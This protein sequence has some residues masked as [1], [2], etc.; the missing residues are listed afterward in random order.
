MPN[1]YRQ[2]F[3][4]YALVPLEDG[5]FLPVNRLY[6]PLGIA[7]SDFV[8]YEKHPTRV[9]IN[10]LTARKARSIGLEVK[11]EAGSYFYFYSDRNNP[12]RSSS[13]WNRYQAI[14]SKLMKMTVA[15]AK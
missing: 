14:L 2:I 5:S 7:S 15:P 1:T 6:K 11:E 9:K 4:P 13:N 10:G 12:E 3:L 8:K